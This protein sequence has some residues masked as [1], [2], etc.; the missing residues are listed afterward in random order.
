MQNKFE[1]AYFY[2]SVYFKCVRFF[3][4]YE[5]TYVNCGKQEKYG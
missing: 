5:Y 3:Y 1:C 4:F 2:D